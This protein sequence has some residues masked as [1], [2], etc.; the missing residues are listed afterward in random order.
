[1]AQSFARFGSEVFLVES[2]HGILPMEDPDATKIVLASMERDG[3]KLL[4]CGRE[5]KI[6]RVDGGGMRLTVES[7]GR[8]YDE[9]VEQL[10]VAV[11]RTPNVEGYAP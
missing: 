6:E 2:A 11:G 7:E 9:V 4:C 5:L 10:L 1:M 3:V 8:E